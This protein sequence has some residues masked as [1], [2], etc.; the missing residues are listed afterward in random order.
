[1]E[2]V[3]SIARK[4]TNKSLLLFAAITSARLG[5][6]SGNPRQALNNLQDTLA[7]AKAAGFLNGEFEVRLAL[8]EIEMK[9]GRLASGRTRLQRLKQDAEAKGFLLISRKAAA[10]Y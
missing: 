10:A 7:T 6:A 4:S 1:M 8:G 5:A 9:S 3:T 2:Q